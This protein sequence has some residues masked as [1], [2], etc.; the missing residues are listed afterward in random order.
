[1]KTRI[2][3]R[4][5]FNLELDLDVKRSR[6]SIVK[7]D[8]EE[9]INQDR[10]FKTISTDTLTERHGDRFRLYSLVVNSLEW[11]AVKFRALL[12]TEVLRLARTFLD[13]GTEGS[14]LINYL[15]I[16]FRRVLF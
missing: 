5:D 16:I 13:K 8:V 1:M 14:V 12:R 15:E 2:K 9:G 7:H 6:S 10:D 11:H 4:I 3:T